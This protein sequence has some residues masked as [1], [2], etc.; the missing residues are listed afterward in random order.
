V[1]ASEDRPAFKVLFIAPSSFSHDHHLPRNSRLN[2]TS[3]CSHLSSF[4]I[5]AQMVIPISASS[6][7]AA[8]LYL[9][10]RQIKNELDQ[11]VPRLLQSYFSDLEVHNVGV[12]MS[13]ARTFPMPLHL[14]VTLDPTVR[15]EHHCRN[16]AWFQEILSLQIDIVA[17]SWAEDDIK[18][19]FDY[20]ERMMNIM[21]VHVASAQRVILD[22]LITNRE[23]A[24]IIDALSRDDSISGWDRTSSV[25][26]ASANRIRL[27]VNFERV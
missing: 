10:C 2:P 25:Q 16:T 20:A 22:H 3:A 19:I 23:W 13:I 26:D 4:H 21:Q 11:E 18:T 14:D 9:S 7:H 24:A 6:E 5:Y 15:P 8:G 27:R 12:H 1:G 17:I